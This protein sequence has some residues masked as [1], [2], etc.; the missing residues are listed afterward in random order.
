MPCSNMCNNT[1]STALFYYYLIYLFILQS[2]RNPV[3]TVAL[4]GHDRVLERLLK[5]GIDVNDR[6]E[7]S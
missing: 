7:V 3:H 4:R 2:G 5:V 1:L 6:D